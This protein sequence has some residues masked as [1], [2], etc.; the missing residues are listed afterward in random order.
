MTTIKT[1]TLVD[2]DDI[3]VFLTTKIIEQTNLVDL[4]KVFG[5]GLDAINFLKENK[6]NVDALPE[7]ILL[8]LSMPIMNGWQFL[9]KY[10]KLNPTIGKKI[11]I[12]IC[13][14]SISPDDITRAKTISEVSDYIIKPITKDKLIDLI[15]K[16]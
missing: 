2:D 7:I 11:T 6:N 8:D 3:F 10:N 16:L 9:E 4:I 5:N 14:S 15:K 1:L 13:S 12:Y